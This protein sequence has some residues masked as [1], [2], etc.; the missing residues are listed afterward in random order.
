[1]IPTRRTLLS[2]GLAA[3][4]WGL[5]AR[6]QVPA[7]AVDGFLPFEV[8]PSRLRLAPSPADPA[9]TLSYAGATPGPLLR[10]KKG[11]ELKLRLVNKLAEPTALSFPGLRAA[12]ASAGYGG[13]TQPRLQPGASADI[14][15]SP[16]DSGF[17][18]YLPHAGATDAGQ[19]GRELSARLSS[20]RPIK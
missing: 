17:N 7:L 8:S 10:L 16:P 2:G 1:M 19:Q 18:L 5:S 4:A 11:E 3:A 6:A 9:S 14:R 20:K 12:N 15:F 13:L